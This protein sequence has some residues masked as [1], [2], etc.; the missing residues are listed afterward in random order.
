SYLLALRRLIKLLTQAHQYDAAI[1]YAQKAIQVDPLREESH[2]VLMR[3]YNAIGRPH[4]ALRQYRELERILASEL[5]ATPSENAQE[6]AS[7]LSTPPPPSAPCAAPARPPS[8]SAPHFPR[9]LTRLFGIETSIAEVREMLAT[10]ET[11]LVTL[12]GLGGFG[13]TRLAL[14]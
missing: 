6:L 5:S 9:P 10:P 14:R 11:R 2:R 7:S 8:P 13:K 1:D 3:L 12:T 4:A